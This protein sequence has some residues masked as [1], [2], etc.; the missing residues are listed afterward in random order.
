MTK[1]H[2]KAIHVFIAIVAL[3]GLALGLSDSI[4]S[5]YFMDAYQVTAHQRGLIELPR[6]SPG[7]IAMFII[8]GLAFLGDIRLAIIAQFLSIVGIMAMGLLSPTFGMMLVF[9]FINSLGM[10][11]FIPLYDSIGMSL[12]K[13]GDYGTMLGRFNGIRT[14][15]SVVAALLIFVGFRFGFFSFTTPIILNFVI[16]GILLTIVFFLLF[17]LHPHP[18]LALQRGLEVFVG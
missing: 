18:F 2:D 8:S 11:L 17:Y 1:R 13:K 4:F 16:A 3:S 7:I 9:L 15:F 6:E 12:A 10:H 5:N 14:A